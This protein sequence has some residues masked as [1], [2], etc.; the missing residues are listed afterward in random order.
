MSSN[1]KHQLGVAQYAIE[2]FA[3]ILAN[4]GTLV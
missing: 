3:A 1:K 2:S 4:T